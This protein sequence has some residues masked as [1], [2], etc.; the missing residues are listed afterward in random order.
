MK[1]LG[2]S[3]RLYLLQLIANRGPLSLTQLDRAAP[4][5]G[6]AAQVEIG[7]GATVADFVEVMLNQGVLIRSDDER[8]ALSPLGTQLVRSLPR[9]DV[10]EAVR[11]TPQL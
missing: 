5:N 2:S 11:Q 9:K 10:A 4:T 7:R 8:L 3:S 1:T 6:Q